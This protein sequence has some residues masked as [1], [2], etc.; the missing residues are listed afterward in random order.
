MIEPIGSMRTLRHGMARASRPLEL[1][2]F[3]ALLFLALAAFGNGATAAAQETGPL[4]RGVVLEGT[5][6]PPIETADVYLV[7]G[8]GTR[9]LGA[10]TDEGGRFRF[11][12]PGPGIYRLKVDRLGY[13]SGEEGPM[14]LTAGDTLDVT[15]SLLP[16]PILLDTLLATVPRRERPMRPVEQL[17]AGRLI[18]DETGQPIADGTVGLYGPWESPLASTITNDEGLFRLV[19][20]EPGRYRL[21]AERMGYAP[22]E[23]PALDLILGDTIF[24]EFRMSVRPIPLGAITVTASARPWLGRYH[25]FARDFYHR[26]A[27]FNR[28]MGEF[29]IRDTI[30]KYEGHVGSV[31]EMLTRATK[32]V[33]WW[34]PDGTLQMAPHGVRIVSRQGRQVT[35]TQKCTPAVFLNGEPASTY[36]LP[37]LT[38]YDLEA[39][40]VY[41]RSEI[42]IEFRTHGRPICG[43][44]GLWTRR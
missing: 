43:V 9:I 22:G 1:P 24:L 10:V 17:V 40:E 16:D 7:D 19:S 32:A 30:A 18:D 38:P 31:G 34:E 42:P 44:V 29:L 5:D 15:V 36:I 35:R 37:S 33:I 13:T 25:G 8:G 26:Y 4:I 20:P 2:L 3:P 11:T 12:A 23:S 21:K 27:T 41:E 14:A 39:V 28:N 6:G